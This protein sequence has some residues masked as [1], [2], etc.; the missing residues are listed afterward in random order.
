MCIDE[1]KNI[2]NERGIKIWKLQL[3]EKNLM[4]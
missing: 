4:N 2:K 3:Q 1:W